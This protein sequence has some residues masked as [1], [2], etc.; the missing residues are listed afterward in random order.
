MGG[1][2]GSFILEARG[3]GLDRV[4]DDAV[5]ALAPVEDTHPAV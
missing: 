5:V 1:G 3:H 2:G 4:L